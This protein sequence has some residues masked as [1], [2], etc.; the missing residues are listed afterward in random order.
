M[1]FTLRTSWRKFQ[2]VRKMESERKKME[3]CWV[4]FLYLYLYPVADNKWVMNVN[5]IPDNK[6]RG[7]SS[8]PLSC[9]L[10]KQ[11]V[12]AGSGGVTMVNPNLLSL[13]SM[14]IPGPLSHCAK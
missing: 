1:V 3:C 7:S 8:M 13:L 2:Q 9:I 5:V 6:R 11:E 14:L 12:C 10:V 4:N